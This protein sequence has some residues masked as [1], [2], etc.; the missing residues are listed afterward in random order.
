MYAATARY[1]PFGMEVLEAALSRCAIIANDIPSFREIW[2][3]DAIYFRTGLTR[4]AWL[5]RFAS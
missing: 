2:G 3:D 4:P 5:L 1:E